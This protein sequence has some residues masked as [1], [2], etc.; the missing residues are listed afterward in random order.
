MTFEEKVLAIKAK[1]Q[2]AADELLAL[3][4]ESPSAVSDIL[5][6]VHPNSPSD[7]KAEHVVER[8]L[9]IPD[10][11]PSTERIGIPY[12]FLDFEKQDVRHETSPVET[13]IPKGQVFVMVG[14]KPENEK[15][16]Q[17]LRDLRTGR[18]T[19][20]EYSRQRELINEEEGYLYECDD[21]GF[22]WEDLLGK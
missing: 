11:S 7:I 19:P 18:L 8:T 1:F 15:R 3:V 5:Q 6:V 21:T 10:R 9:F 2:E 14:I 17:A 22:S 4:S 12:V 13:L 20:D 16:S